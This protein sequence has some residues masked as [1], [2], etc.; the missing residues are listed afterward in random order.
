MKILDVTNARRFE[1][2]YWNLLRIPYKIN[3]IL[4]AT[5]E[6]FFKFSVPVNCIISHYLHNTALLQ[7]WSVD[8]SDFSLRKGERLRI[9]NKEVL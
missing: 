7:L 2:Y 4:N 1:K 3:V 5:T 8:K 6:N 9:Q